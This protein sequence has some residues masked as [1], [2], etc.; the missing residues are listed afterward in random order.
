MV[1]ERSSR[2]NLAELCV[3][4]PRAARRH[5][6]IYVG[7]HN[8]TGL[9]FGNGHLVRGD[10]FVFECSYPPAVLRTLD[11]TPTLACLIPS[12]VAAYVVEGDTRVSTLLATA[13]A[14]HG[15][16]PPLARAQQLQVARAYDRVMRR[17]LRDLCARRS[18][19]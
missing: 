12:R 16:L 3:E 11:S 17:L 13:I 2:C 8:L 9:M 19:A 18:T 10:H 14:R 1:L 5:G 4:F 15:R 7:C 6:L